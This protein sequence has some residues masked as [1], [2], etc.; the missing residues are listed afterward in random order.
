MGQASAKAKTALAG[1]IIFTTSI[2]IYVHAVHYIERDVSFTL[3][4]YR[5]QYKVELRTGHHS[6]H[7]HKK[8]CLL[9]NTLYIQN[10]FSM[11][12]YLLII[13]SRSLDKN[14]LIQMFRPDH[15]KS[16]SL[17]CRTGQHPLHDFVDPGEI[18]FRQKSVW[19]V[20]VSRSAKKDFVLVY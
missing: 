7:W 4:L 20:F 18:L 14:S 10:V 6:G 16:P 19:T 8:C 15:T 12:I 17:I 3:N 1:S 13:M 5:W 11:V 9:I 2:V